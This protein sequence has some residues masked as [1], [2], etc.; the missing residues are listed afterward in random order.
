MKFQKGQI[1]HNKGNAKLNYEPLELVSTKLKGVAKSVEYAR[2]ISENK[3]W[4]INI[5]IMGK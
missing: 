4:S 3:E 1:P 2:K 5:Q